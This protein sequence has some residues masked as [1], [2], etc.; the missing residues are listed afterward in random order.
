MFEL[1]RIK[2]REAFS[3]VD[4]ITYDQQRGQRQ[5]IL[6]D[7]LRQVFQF[8]PID[9]LLF[10]SQLVAS[11]YGGGRRIGLQELRLYLPHYSQLLRGFLAGCGDRLTPAEIAALPMG[12]KLM[13]L[14]CG[15]R[16]LTDYLM[17]DV[18]FHIHRPGHNLDRCRTQFKL[19]GSMEE[20]W[21]A[22]QSALRQAD[23]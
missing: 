21:S 13:T 3:V 14:E 17:G 18:Y 11:R 2:A 20:N 6:F 5:V 15:V 12:G 19:V 23:C 16:F 1:M 4:G 10:P 8:T 7:N 9:A 22:M